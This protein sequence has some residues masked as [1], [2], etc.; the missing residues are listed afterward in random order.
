VKNNPRIKIPVFG[1]GDLF[2][3]KHVKEK[4]D[5]YGID[6]VMIGRGAIGY[7]WIFNEIKQF[8]NYNKIIPAP[9]I[10][11]R[12]NVVRNHLDLSIKWKGEKL[13][14]LE[15]RRHYANYFKGF[16]GIK[17]YRKLLVCQDSYLELKNVLSNLEKT[18]V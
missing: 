7:P 13:G 2:S 14:I 1:N 4:K 18:I 11:E 5:K 17:N 12:V 9:S 3:A 15:M 16:D 8:L 6:G 10:K